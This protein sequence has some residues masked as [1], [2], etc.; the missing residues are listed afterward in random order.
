MTNQSSTGHLKKVVGKK[1]PGDVWN[2]LYQLN[3]FAAKLGLLP[4]N[5][6]YAPKKVVG[7]PRAIAAVR[8]EP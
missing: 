1:K 6:G 5:D 8:S 7:K 2:E 3:A 4:A